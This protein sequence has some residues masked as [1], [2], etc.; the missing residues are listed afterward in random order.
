MQNTRYVITVAIAALT[1]GGDQPL[2][3]GHVDRQWFLQEYVLAGLDGL[4]AVHLD[5]EV[6]RVGIAAVAR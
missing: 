6:L 1:S 5:A 2:A 3:L 4:A